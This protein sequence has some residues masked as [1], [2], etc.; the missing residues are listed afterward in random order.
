MEAC[1]PDRV[2]SAIFF[3]AGGLITEGWSG[4]DVAWPYFVAGFALA[5]RSLSNGGEPHRLAG[6]GGVAG[7]TAFLFVM[8]A[9]PLQSVVLLSIGATLIGFGCG[10]FS[11]GTLTAAMAISSRDERGGRTG[12]ALGA[13]GAVQATSA[14][15]AIA[16]GAVVRDAVSA[17]SLVLAR[18]KNTAE[19]S[20]A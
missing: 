9:A 1:T 13:W 20:A 12:L 11:V 7:I 17:M 15:V 3:L 6:L 8:F 14:G 2:A 18:V 5:A 19:V 16:L 10:L 4:V